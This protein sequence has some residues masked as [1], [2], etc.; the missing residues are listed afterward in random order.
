MWSGLFN[1]FHI[2]KGGLSMNTQVNNIKTATGTRKKTTL[3]SLKRKKYIWAYIFIFPQLLFY[4]GFTLYPMVMSYVYVFF[5]WD[6]IGP[7]SDFVGLGNFISIVHD[8]VFWGSVAHGFI[9]MGGLVVIVMPC[10]FLLAFLLNSSLLH[11]KTLFR[12]IYFIPVVSVT[13]IMGVVMKLIFGSGKSLFNNLLIHL[14]IIDH[15]IPWLQNSVS[16]M[17]IL[18]CVGSWIAMGTTMIYWLAALQTIPNDVYES[19]KIDGAGPFKSFRYITIPL[20]LPSAAVILLL[21]IVH[22]F[23]VFDLAKTLTD[24]GPY[25]ATTTV[26]LYIYDLVFGNFSPRIGYAS[27]AGIIFGLMSF[28]ITTSLV[29]FGNIVRNRING[30]KMSTKA[31]RKVQL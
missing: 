15:A 19:A 21:T 22:G 5:H 8:K 28:V 10:S 6:G 14:G 1:P 16:A 25:Y 7:L 12:T 3:K 2:I 27:A 4:V 11:W 26:D 20:I 13:A 30:K 17:I 23:N 9:Y 29:L 31:I 18:I 24:G